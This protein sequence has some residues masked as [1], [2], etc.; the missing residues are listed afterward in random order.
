MHTHIR[1]CANDD[2]QSNQNTSLNSY[3]SHKIHCMYR[4]LRFM[5][6]SNHIKLEKEQNSKKNEVNQLGKCMELHMHWVIYQKNVCRD[7]ENFRLKCIESKSIP[8]EF[9]YI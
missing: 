2:T 1:I 7:P 5:T 3:T 6:K 8:S 9:V 4:I